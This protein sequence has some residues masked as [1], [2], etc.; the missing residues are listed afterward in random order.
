MRAG[1]S[2]RVLAIGRLIL[3]LTTGGWIFSADVRPPIRLFRADDLTGWEQTA[4]NGSMRWV[5]PVWHPGF[6]WDEAVPSWN[7]AVGSAW[8]FEL[9]SVDLDRNSAWYSLGHWCSDTNQSPRSSV[10][11]QEDGDGRVATDTLILKHP[12]KGIQ[13][14][15]TLGSRTTTNDF[16]Q[17]AVSVLAT[18]DRWPE[19]AAFPEA[20]GRDLAVP[21]RSQADFPEG[22]QSWCSPASVTM[23]LGWWSTASRNLAQT[24]AV[25][26]VPEAAR[27]VF[28]PGWPGT[29]NWA[30]NVAYLGQTPGLRSAVVRLAGMADLERWIASG[31]PVAASVSYAIL[32]GRPSAESG[33]GHIVVV[34]GFSAH[35]EVL[36]ND[37]GVRASRVQRSVGRSAFSAA[38]AQSRNTAYVVWPE[39][40]QLPAGGDGRW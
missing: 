39:G 10:A 2:R 1:R 20:W 27:G 21:I 36:V 4:T 23:I 13:A 22:V 6:A 12:A 8:Q 32:K 17:F 25:P 38:W 35:G 33:D 14:R 40:S 34:R 37:P 9:R 18:A 26:T 7:V 11:G 19:T 24:P 30:F 29:G 31:L 28:D 16:N 3:A 5:S 15:L